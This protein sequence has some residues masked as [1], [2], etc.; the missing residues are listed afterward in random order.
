L[1]REREREREKRE[2]AI[3]VGFAL[4]GG[5]QDLSQFEKSFIIYIFKKELGL[6]FTLVRRQK[7]TEDR[8]RRN[9]RTSLERAFLR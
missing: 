2:I 9:P 6:C 7:K 5:R 3:L 1:K 8:R 4:G